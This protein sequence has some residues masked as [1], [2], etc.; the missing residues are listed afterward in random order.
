LL[1]IPLRDGDLRRDGHH[2]VQLLGTRNRRARNRSPNADEWSR[3]A[4][5][6]NRVGQNMNEPRCAVCPKLLSGLR[7]SART[8]S[9]RCRKKLSRLRLEVENSAVAAF[10]KLAAEATAEASIVD[11]ERN[12]EAAKNV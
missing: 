3:V 8:C 2:L 6:G 5:N 4:L 10:E 7:G 9:D 11:P 12:G 1:S